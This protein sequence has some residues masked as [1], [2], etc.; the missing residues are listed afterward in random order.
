MRHIFDNLRTVLSY[1]L[2]LTIAIAPVQVI[3]ATQVMDHPSPQAQERTGG[4]ESHCVT[5]T[6]TK[7]DK[8]YLADPVI[9]KTELACDCCNGVCDCPYCDQGCHTASSVS[10]LN[11]D[12][13]PSG[14]FT[15]V[16]QAHPEVRL[17]SIVTFPLDI[18]PVS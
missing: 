4:I 13:A 14:R 3:G 9:E 18:P 10:L 7:T 17:R 2:I 5:M 16:M 1:L 11:S 12:S 6:T 15:L 8:T